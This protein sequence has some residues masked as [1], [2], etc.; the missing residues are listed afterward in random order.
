MLLHLQIT[1]IAIN[2]F[3]L[4]RNIIKDSLNYLKVLYF[5]MKN[6][7]PYYITTKSFAK[8][9]TPDIA[10]YRALF[11]NPHFPLPYRIESTDKIFDTWKVQVLFK[12]PFHVRLNPESSINHWKIKKNSTKWE[13]KSFLQFLSTKHPSRLKEALACRHF[14][15]RLILFHIYSAEIWFTLQLC[16]VLKLRNCSVFRRHWQTATV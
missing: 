1:K 4:F 2:R 11:Y 7:I 8:A 10:V 13:R 14:M 15:K 6:P 3:C 12:H 5:I 9:I 16:Q